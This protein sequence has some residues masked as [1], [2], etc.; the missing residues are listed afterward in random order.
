MVMTSFLGESDLVAITEKKG[1]DCMTIPSRIKTISTSIFNARS[2][3][4][5]DLKPQ[6]LP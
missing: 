2:Y 3:Y 1:N 6:T 4:L 5:V